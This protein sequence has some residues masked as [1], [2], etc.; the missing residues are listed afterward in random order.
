[1]AIAA[2]PLVRIAA[3]QLVFKALYCAWW[4]LALHPMDHTVYAVQLPNLG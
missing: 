4:R 2:H 1:M 3:L